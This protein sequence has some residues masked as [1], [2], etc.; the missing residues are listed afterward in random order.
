MA[1]A[2]DAGKTV[3]LKALRAK[4]LKR[5]GVRQAFEALELEFAIAQ[6]VIDARAKA[7]LSQAE[8]AARMGAKQS[9]IARLESGRGL[10]AMATLRRVAEATGMKAK[11]V[12]EGA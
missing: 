9:F 12:F 5:P 1:K 3:T 4:L 10:P 7:G 11:F 6:A 8:L 2:K